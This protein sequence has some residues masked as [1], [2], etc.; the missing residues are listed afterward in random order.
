MINEIPKESNETQPTF[1]TRNGV[2]IFTGIQYSVVR[3]GERP[4]NWVDGIQ[5][6]TK[7][8]VTINGLDFGTWRIYARPSEDGPVVICGDIAIV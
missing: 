3:V 8:G 6:G 4:S 2:Q 1:I 7:T 5:D